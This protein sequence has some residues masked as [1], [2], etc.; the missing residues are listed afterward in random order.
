MRKLGV[1]IFVFLVVSLVVI[2]IGF[3]NGDDEDP[4]AKVDCEK[5]GAV[6]DEEG[7][8]NDECS[9]EGSPSSV[10]TTTYYSDPSFPLI[11]YYSS[12]NFYSSPPTY[13]DV[14]YRS[15]SCVGKKYGDNI[16]CCCTCDECFSET[17]R[18][19]SWQRCTIS[20]GCMCDEKRCE[21][22]CIKNALIY[23][24]DEYCGCSKPRI[25]EKGKYKLKEP[26]E[27]KSFSKCKEWHCEGEDCDIDC[28][29]KGLKEDYCYCSYFEIKD[30]YQ[31][32]SAI[33]N[34]SH[35]CASKNCAFDFTTGRAYCCPD[36]GCPY[37]PGLT[38]REGDSR[39]CYSDGSTIIHNGY[40]LKC[41]NGVWEFDVGCGE[42][43]FNFQFYYDKDVVYKGEGYKGP[44]SVVY[45]IKF[46]GTRIIKAYISP[47]NSS[48][49]IQIIKDG[50]VIAEE[51]GDKVLEKTVTLHEG[52][53][54]GVRIAGTG[55]YD[56]HV[57]CY[58]PYGDDCSNSENIDECLPDAHCIEDNINN[59]YY[60]C[61]Y[62]ECAYNGWCYSKGSFLRSWK[63][64]NE[65]WSRSDRGEG[66]I[67]DEDCKYVGAYRSD[68]K[69][70]NL[71]C[72]STPDGINKFCCEEGKCAIGKGYG[73]VEQGYT[74]KLPT[75]I[76]VCDVDATNRGVWKCINSDIRSDYFRV[77][78]TKTK[79]TYSISYDISDLEVVRNTNAKLYL[80]F[81][82]G[83]YH[84]NVDISITDQNGNN[85]HSQSYVINNK[86]E[87][88]LGNINPGTRSDEVSEIKIT[89]ASNVDEKEYFFYMGSI[90]ILDN[91]S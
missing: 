87:I 71:V 28:Y 4:C 8:C 57:E 56:L 42:T 83:N 41:N 29:C 84:E 3:C 35:P 91:L 61:H 2:Q 1:F 20:N 45:P 89:I 55:E 34:D 17:I 26:K 10:S 53:K 25:V 43:I 80:F 12:D 39:I 77:L 50:T 38:K 90:L 22:F 18:C 15:Y 31:C 78:F 52:Q 19:K 27:Y 81:D 88:N 70:Y 33:V 64:F 48:I 54:A 6:I 16:V 62:G 24:G 11:K 58:I 85:L 60:C 47:L 76:C 14:K 46:S 79:Q 37:N 13:K 9:G 82:I 72:V 69:E 68:L 32:D 5:I 36:G 63:C 30:Y 23:D 65:R 40:K 49:K 74:I 21:A 73:C 67:R 66:C 86:I 51:D 44:F 75:G 59:A 7:L